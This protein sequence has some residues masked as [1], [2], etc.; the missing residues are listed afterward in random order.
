[1]C[2]DLTLPPWDVIRIYRLRF[3]IEVSSS[4]PFHLIGDFWTMAAM[5][6]LPRV[7]G[8]QHRTASR[9]IPQHRP[10]RERGLPPSRPTRVAQG[11]LQI[12][13]AI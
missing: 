3:K 5:A 13:S 8:N 11:L 12:L 4:R 9:R 7:S 6:P 1:M 10:P 2:T